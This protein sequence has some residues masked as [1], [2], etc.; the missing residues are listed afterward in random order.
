MNYINQF[1]T[2]YRRISWPLYIYGSIRSTVQPFLN[3][4]FEANEILP[5]LWLGNIGSASN[6]QALD[7][8]HIKNIVSLAIGTRSL[9]ND[10]HYIHISLLDHPDEQIIE[11][12]KPILP[13]V[14]QLLLDAK[15]VLIHCMV[16]A[17]RS[18]AF[19]ICYCMKYKSWSLNYCLDFIKEKRP[20]ISPNTGYLV[21]LQNYEKE[22][23]IPSLL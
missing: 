20:L 3:P 21:Q 22:L 7:D 23:N 17:S 19:L 15:P 5:N 11:K 6:K 1:L 9:F 18:V 8:H 12:I 16:G 2:K 13:I 14:H 10:I 4:T